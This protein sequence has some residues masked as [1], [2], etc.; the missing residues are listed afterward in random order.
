[1]EEPYSSKLSGWHRPVI[2]PLVS[3]PRFTTFLYPPPFTDVPEELQ[4]LGAEYARVYLLACEQGTKAVRRTRVMLVGHF[5]A[6]KT[7]LK[8]R[9]VNEA[10]NPEYLITNGIDADPSACTIQVD[11]T[12]NW[13]LIQKGRRAKAKNVALVYK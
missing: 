7:S 8:R 5:S 11:D 10:F 4:Y 12:C 3:F 1:M 9:L 6:G 2:V 13:S